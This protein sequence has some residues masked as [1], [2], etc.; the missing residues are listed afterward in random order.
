MTVI[1]NLI[2]ILAPVKREWTLYTVLLHHKYRG[3]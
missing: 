3:A 1:H 2:G